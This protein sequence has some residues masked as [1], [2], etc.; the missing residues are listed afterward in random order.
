MAL[1]RYRIHAHKMSQGQS[2]KSEPSSIEQNDEKVQPPPPNQDDPAYQ[3]DNERDMADD[4][5]SKGKGNLVTTQ[6]GIIKRPKRVRKLRCKICNNVFNSTKEWNKHYEENHPLLPCLDCGKMFRN[7]K[8]L[9]H[10][11]YTHTKTTVI[12]PCTKCEQVFPFV[13]QL[14]SHIFTHRKVKHFPC[15]ATSCQKVFKTEWNRLTHEKSHSTPKTQCTQCDYSTNDLRYLKQHMRVHSD[16]CKHKCPQCG[17]GFH[18]YEQ[19]KR[20]FAKPCAAH[21]AE[22]NN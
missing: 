4:T 2:V 12:F 3:A 8:S 21:K 17:Q 14:E 13:S 15:T 16:V 20:H 6:H 10:H 22:R 1:S 11:R 19:M 18:F 5:G 7:P 9:Y